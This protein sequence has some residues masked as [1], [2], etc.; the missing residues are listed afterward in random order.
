MNSAVNEESRSERREQLAAVPG[1]NGAKRNG[2]VTKGTKVGRAEKLWRG[3]EGLSVGTKCK[4]LS[5]G[6]K[7]VRLS[8]KD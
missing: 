2:N 1:S 4:G 6:T 5:V 3:T 8:V 7:C